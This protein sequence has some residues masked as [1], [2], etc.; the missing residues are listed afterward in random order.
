[1]KER[2]A[3]KQLL[4]DTLPEAGTVYHACKA[5]GVSLA[6][7]NRWLQEDD[8]FADAIRTVKKI[9]G[10][11]I[12]RVAMRRALDARINAD[13]LRI[14]MLKNLLPDSYGESD[15]LSLEIKIQDVLVSH[16]VSVIQQTVPEVCPHCKTHLGL[17]ES[18]ARELKD[19]S[20]RVGKSDADA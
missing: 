8:A 14:F 15:K 1:M 9:P 20:A 19:Y 3:K 16:F 12:E 6:T 13:P 17:S 4:I 2:R 18:L 11:M 7:Y 5:A 10:H